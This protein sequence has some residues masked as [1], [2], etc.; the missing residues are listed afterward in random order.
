MIEKLKGGKVEEMIVDALLVCIG[1]RPLTNNIG[2]EEVGIAK[3]AQVIPLYLYFLE[4]GHTSCFLESNLMMNCLPIR[5]PIIKDSGICFI[6]KTLY[7][8][9]SSGP[10]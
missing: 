6:K 10:M 5:W 8:T 2:C 7:W 9:R 1:R 3:D 4:D